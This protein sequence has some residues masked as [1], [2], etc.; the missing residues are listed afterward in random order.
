MTSDAQE[1]LQ[2]ALLLPENER[3][4]LAG[5]LIASLDQNIDTDSD[6]LWQEEVARRAA[7]VRA[8]KVTTTPWEE[9]QHKARTLL[10]GK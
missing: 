1:L 9:V 4:E 5:S 6:A 3:A 8:G 10:H 7:E 2:K